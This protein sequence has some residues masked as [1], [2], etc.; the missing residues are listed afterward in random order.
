MVL[1]ATGCGGGRKPVAVSGTI[2]LD[3]KPLAG[4]TVTFSPVEGHGRSA[5]GLTDDSGEFDL[6]TFNS[7]DG[8]LP[9]DYKVI[10][11][12]KDMSAVEQTLQNIGSGG[13]EDKAMKMMGRRSPEQK[14]KV[15]AALKKAR[16]LVPAVYTKL[17]STP[18]TQ[19][20]PASGKVHL[21]LQGDAKGK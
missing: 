5:G 4:A 21:E 19:H 17:D 11:D 9:G 14:A 10:V 15:N 13:P 3:G 2:T 8:A 6:T 16:S 20:V 1:A 18:L 7:G 12:L